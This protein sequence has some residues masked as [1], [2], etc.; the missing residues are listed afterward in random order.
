MDL[1]RVVSALAAA[2]G[3]AVRHKVHLRTKAEKQNYWFPSEVMTL[4][5]EEA[6][7][8]GWNEAGWKAPPDPEN[9]V[10]WTDDYSNI[11]SAILRKQGAL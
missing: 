1:S 7:M 10:P 2:D 5:R 3:W 11:L 4:A 9:V 8:S 6:H